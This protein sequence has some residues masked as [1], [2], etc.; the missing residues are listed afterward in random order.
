VIVQNPQWPQ[1]YAI[2]REQMQSARPR[3]P[4]PQWPEISRAIQT[5]M[6]E[7]ITGTKPADAALKEAARKI[8][9]ILAKTP[10]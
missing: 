7:A 4:H 6:Q 10:L 2:Y 9:P 3:G 8:Q 5:A 1:A